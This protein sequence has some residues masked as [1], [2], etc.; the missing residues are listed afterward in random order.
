DVF[1]TFE[2]DNHILLQLVA[3]GLL[4]DFSSSFGELDQLGMVRFVAGLAVDTVIERTAV[5]KLLERIKDVLPGGDDAWDSEAGLLD[6]EYQLAMFRWREEHMLSGVARR[7][8]RGMD[9]HLEPAEVFSRCQDHVIALARAHVERLV[10]EA[11]VDKVRAAPEGDNREALALLCDLHALTTIESG[12]AWWMEHGRLS[13]QRSKA[14][15]AEIGSLC[16]RLRPIAQD[17]VDAFGVPAEMRAAEL[18]RQED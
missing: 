18:L 14:I 2:G 8:K 15:T 13:S 7:L 3:K 16:R 6:S 9:S 11:F 1:T 4:T 17:L 10:L 12:R 5:H